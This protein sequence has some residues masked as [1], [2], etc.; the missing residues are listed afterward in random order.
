MFCADKS[1]RRRLRYPVDPF[2][3]NHILFYWITWQTHNFP[4]DYILWDL[5]HKQPPTPVCTNNTTAEGIIHN[6]FKQVRFLTIDMLYHW[7]KD[8]SNM[9][10]FY[11]YW[12]RVD[13]NLGYYYTK[14]HPP[15]H[16]FKMRPIVLNNPS[17]TQYYYSKGVLAVSRRRPKIPTRI[18]ANRINR[19]VIDQ[20]KKYRDYLRKIRQFT[21]NRII[22]KLLI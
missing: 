22:N 6:T 14:H 20:S 4:V 7:V 19:T 5:D 16:Q 21:N 18:T 8:R 11:I 9:N 13:G 15:W 12:D 17:D 2:F 10:Q 3:D 1:Q